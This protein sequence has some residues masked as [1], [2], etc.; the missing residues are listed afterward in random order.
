MRRLSINILILFTILALFSCGSG[1]SSDNKMASTGRMESFDDVLPSG[2]EK[3]NKSNQ[4]GIRKL[5]K[6]GEIRFQT[7][8]T[9]K[10]RTRIES[11]VQKH[12]GY[13][14][15]DNVS[16]YSDRTEHELTVRIPA[17]AFDDFVSELV[18]GIEYID[19]QR[20]NVEDVT[21]KFVDIQ[22]R[23]KSK[24]AME[25]RL[26]DLLNKAG[27]VKEMLEVETEL[28]KVRADIESMQQLMNALSKNIAYS[29]LKIIFFEKKAGPKKAAR[30]IGSAFM[31]GVDLLSDIFIGMLKI[32]PVILIFLLVVFFII[33]HDRKRKKQEREKKL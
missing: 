15:N 25:Q 4:Q 12:N 30:S 5:V 13:L 24:K 7:G 22:A 19:Y 26:L 23:L 33:R 8:D 14:G 3:M 2:P 16:T 9:K 18:Q 31:K 17:K 29:R 11:L 1:A 21:A 10:T 28:G 32:W 27:T 20:I 6:R